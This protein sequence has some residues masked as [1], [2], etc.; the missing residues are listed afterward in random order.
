MNSKII[1]KYILLSLPF[2][3]GIILY[4]IG[5]YNLVS[6]LLFFVGGYTLIKNLCDYRKINKNIR[7]V[8]SLNGIKLE[9]NSKNNSKVDNVRIS[10]N[11]NRYRDYDSIPGIKCTRRY[12]KIRRRI[13]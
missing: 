1:K 5:I 2:V 10:N 13:K 3:S 11:Y 12:I 6:S 4:S 8:S 9:D 7:L